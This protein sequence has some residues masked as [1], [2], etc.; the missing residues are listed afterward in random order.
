MIGAVASRAAGLIIRDFAWS[1]TAQPST[2][3]A[4][5]LRISTEN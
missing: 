2:C 4:I 1:Q 5:R 3:R